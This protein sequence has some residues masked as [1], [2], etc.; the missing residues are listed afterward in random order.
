MGSTQGG[1]IL[2]TLNFLPF[3]A[4]MSASGT[5][6]LLHPAGVSAWF[7]AWLSSLFGGH[8]YLFDA[9]YSL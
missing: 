1:S 5:P 4:F 6:G 3:T 9:Q 7:P 2:S 8:T